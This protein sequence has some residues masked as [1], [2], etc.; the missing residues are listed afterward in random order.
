M[1]AEQPEL[2]TRPRKRDLACDLTQLTAWLRGREWQ[3]AGEIEKALG[4]DDRYTRRL[5]NGSRGDVI[6]GQNGYRLTMEATLSEIEHARNSLLSQSDEMRRRA[7][8][9]DRVRH[10]RQVRGDADAHG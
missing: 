6:S 5:A 8:E 9:I 3:T 4:F 7:I 10:G 1:S 2:F